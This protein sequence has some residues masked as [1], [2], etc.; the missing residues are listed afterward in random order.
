[1]DPVSVSYANISFANIASSLVSIEKLIT[2]AAYL[3]G[4]SFAIKAIYSMK[5]LAEAKSQM[6]DHG[7]VKE[8]AIYLL[9]AGMLLY[10]P[11]GFAVMMESTFGY[12]QVLAYAP[13]DTGSS[14]L[15]S[16]FGT[17]SPFGSTLALFIQV[18]GLVAFIRGWILIA[19][20]ASTGQPPGGTG[21]G[22][23]HVFGG[24]LAM[25]IVGTLLIVNN[26]LFG[27]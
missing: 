23:T 16:L 6:S 15:N 3:M 19:R 14:T 8:P 5:K 20:A 22:L 24:I 13:I 12:S 25:N 9:V 7:S 26:T 17:G 1:M 18:I 11:T 21:Q 10:F 2:G 27:V 4:I